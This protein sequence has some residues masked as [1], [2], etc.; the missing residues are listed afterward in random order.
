MSAAL[1]A[2]EEPFHLAAGSDLPLVREQL[3]APLH[4]AGF[5]GS[6]EA[7]VSNGAHRCRCRLGQ[8]LEVETISSFSL[9]THL[10]QTSFDEL[11]AGIEAILAAEEFSL[12][13]SGLSVVGERM[14]D[15]GAMLNVAPMGRPMGIDADALRR[16]EAFVQFDKATGFRRRLRERLWQV[17]EPWRASHGLRVNLGGQTSFDIVVVGEDKRRPLRELL[18]DGYEFLTYVGDALEEGGN[19]V[20]VLE[21]IEAWPGPGT[22]PV[23]VVRVAS[24]QDTLEFLRARSA[25]GSPGGKAGA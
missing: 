10:G 14:G 21:F 23:S 7:F 1:V 8:G 13:A 4:E 22:C 12:E 15:R 16:R 9:R 6:F 25:A 2:L 20:A 17:C 3:L 18:R 5:R 24:W 11:C 19:D